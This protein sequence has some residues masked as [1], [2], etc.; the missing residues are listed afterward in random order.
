M[1]NKIQKNL[2]FLIFPAVLGFSALIY[3]FVW[4]AKLPSLIA[5]TTVRE[6]ILMAVGNL[7][8][9]V[10]GVT[11]VVIIIAGVIYLFSGANVSLAEKAKKTLVGAVIG[12]AIVLGADILINQIG[13]A[14]GWKTADCSQAGG[15]HGIVTRMI[16]FLFSILGFIGMIGIIMGAIMYFAAGAD[17]GRSKT[18]KT[19]VI[20]S[21]IGTVLAISAVIIVRQVERI[22][23]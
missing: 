18:G 2:Y 15:A 23:G 3:N 11:V 7:R 21:I 13:C 10:V 9:I 1:L 4:A 5:S 12:F 16:N 19:M 17:E 14:L 20:Y 8:G 22:F 6:C